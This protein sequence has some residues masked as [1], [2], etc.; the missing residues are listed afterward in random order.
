MVS[1]RLLILPLVLGC[2]GGQLDPRTQRALDT[3]ECRVDALKPYVGDVCEVAGLVRDIARGQVD[4][5]R[6]LLT[7]GHTRESIEEAHKAWV[8]C[9]PK[10]EAP[11]TAT[12]KLAFRESP[13]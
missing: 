8:A 4:V 5:S 9:D 11:A 13:F 12:S 6:F 10:P 1:A 2:A 3:F 7:L